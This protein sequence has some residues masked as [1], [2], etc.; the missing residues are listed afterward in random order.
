VKL[1]SV[2]LLKRQPIPN[3]KRY[4]HRSFAPTIVARA[5]RTG[6][7][8]AIRALGRFLAPYAIRGKHD[9]T[10]YD[11]CL[12][13]SMGKAT[14]W[15]PLVMVVLAYSGPALAQ[16][17]DALLIPGEAVAQDIAGAKEMP[18]PDVEYKVLFDVQV[19]APEVT[20]VNP[21]LR[22]TAR[23]LNTLAKAGVP[24]EHRKIAVIFHQ[25]GTDIIMNNEAYKARYDGQDNPNVALIRA[26]KQAGVEFH[27]CGQAVLG[28]KID[29]ETIM[30]EIQV[31]LWALTTIINFELRGY[32]RIGG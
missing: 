18:D 9:G 2:S 14:I 15:T 5:A 8:A 26:L 32:V 27:V 25:G 22:A 10:Q 4:C 20:A 7:A 31:D 3:R 1:L 21:M 16:S 13:V 28:R 12:E 19:A 17:G 30:P 29:P 24:A 11:A 6:R 23:Y